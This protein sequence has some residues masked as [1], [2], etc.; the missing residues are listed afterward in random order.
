MTAVRS[1]GGGFLAAPVEA[2]EARIE[3][4]AGAI[5]VVRP[6]GD[7]PFPVVIQLHGCGGRKPLQGRWAQAVREAGWAAV[8]VDSYAHRRISNTEAYSL[9][10]TG[11]K[12][13]GAERAGD[14]FAA[15]EWVRRQGW[16]DG[17]RIVVAGWSHGGW[18]ALD[19][20][21]MAPGTDAERLTGL[22]GLGAEPLEGLIGAFLV[23][24]YASM[25]SIARMRGLRVDVAPLA[26]VG[27]RDVIVGGRGLASA[28]RRM[29]TPGEEIE[30]VFFDKATHA[31]DEAE[32]SDLRVHF[33]AALTRR[34][35]GLLQD[36]LGRVL[37]RG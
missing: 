2:L 6:D 28:L 1:S 22:T 11:L 27:G 4:L 18:S 37:A 23:Y 34:A 33:D 12:L 26:I 24:P 35:H 31:F 3:G 14:L 21:A 9:V 7:G 16:A 17:G 25:P 5:E 10:C 30:V 20:M 13:R 15:M 8:V 29:R 19:A 32:A 36:Y